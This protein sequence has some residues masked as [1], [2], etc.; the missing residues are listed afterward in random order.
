[1]ERGISQSALSLY[2]SCPY[3]Y[4]LKYFDKCDPIFFDTVPMDVGGLIHDCIHVYYRDGYD[5]SFNDTD[6]FDITYSHLKRN[7]DLSF[8][9]SDY[10]KAYQCLQ[11]HSLWEYDNVKKGIE[12]KPFSELKLSANGF[13][14]IIDYVDIQN[15]RL[16]DFKSNKYPSLSYE[17]RMQ[18]EIYKE[19]FEHNFKKDITHFYFFFLFTNDWRTVS[20][21]DAKQKCVRDDVFELLRSVKSNDF[22]KKPR[23]PSVCNN[24]PYSYYCKILKT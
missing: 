14:G 17:Y 12:V 9:V 2:R 22:D 13:Y 7:W 19:L 20:F 6:I 15:N 8:P 18:A 24:C 3:A 10:A 21:N 1:M 5:T 16:I 23:T 11:N 4:K